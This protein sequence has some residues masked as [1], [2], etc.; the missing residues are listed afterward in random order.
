MLLGWV[1][2]IFFV[3]VQA[4]VWRKQTVSLCGSL[5]Q[6]NCWSFWY[7]RQY[8]DVLSEMIW[9]DNNIK[10]LHSRHITFI[11][12][13]NKR[14]L[15]KPENKQDNVYKKYRT[16]TVPSSTKSLTDI[17]MGNNLIINCDVTPTPPSSDTLFFY[18]NRYNIE[19]LM[20]TVIL[21]LLREF[22][23]GTC[24]FLVLFLKVNKE[25]SIWT[26]K[27]KRGDTF[28][29]YLCSHI[30][31]CVA[32]THSLSLGPE[33]IR[34]PISEMSHRVWVSYKQ[35]ISSSSPFKMASIPRILKD[36]STAETISDVH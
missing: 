31:N 27:H 35:T 24:V 14:I 10:H 16:K 36:H 32:S 17:S 22:G 23:Q 33:V 29:I 6:T 5:G 28:L 11:L 4:N 1:I 13:I 19:P 2:E 26:H 20:L 21:M 18:I 8:V 9:V 12:Y 30:M 15:I 7:I 34:N 3:V 25:R